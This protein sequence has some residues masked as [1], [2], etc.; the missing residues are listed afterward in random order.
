MVD[1]VLVLFQVRGFFRGLGF[2]LVTY[3]AINSLFFGTYGA[4][5]KYM[6]G[7]EHRKSTYMEIYVAGCMGGFSQLFFACPADVVK[8]VLQSQISKTSGN[9]LKPNKESMFVMCYV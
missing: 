2:P 7:G 1:F 3:G 9:Y 8:V 5:L 6:K 4:T